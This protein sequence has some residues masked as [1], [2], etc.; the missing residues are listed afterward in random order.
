[1]GVGEAEDAGFRE[2][3]GKSVLTRAHPGH[4]LSCPTPQTERAG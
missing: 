4:I 1:M 2:P 3:R